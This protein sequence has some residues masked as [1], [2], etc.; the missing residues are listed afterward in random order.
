MSAGD[1][2]AQRGLATPTTPTNLPKLLSLAVHE[3]RSPLSVVSGYIRILL[4]DAARPLPDPQLHF[5][6][7]MEKSC[8]KLSGLLKELSELS[9]LES[10][11]APFNRSTVDVLR[12]V[13]ESSAA[14]PPMPDREVR[15]DVTGEPA[16][17]HGDSVRL[18]AAFTSIL[19]A[20]RRELVSGDSVAVKVQPSSNQV[21]ISICEEAR[22]ESLQQAG[23]DDFA[24]F[25]EWR[26]GNGLSLPTARRVIEAHGGRI[27]GLRDDG[28]AAATIASPTV[29]S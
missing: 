9:R 4:K 27:L 1:K 21:I 25:D 20:L 7:E 8:A 12:L 2:D 3:L 26:G 23:P 5:V 24:T 19:V 14:L 10:G 17:V 18:K 29:P 22:L 11:T 28:K 16:H 6:E 15:I 13:K